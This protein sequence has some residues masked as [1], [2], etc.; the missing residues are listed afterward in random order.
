MAKQNGLA[1][2]TLDLDDAGGTPRDIRS[3]VN[4]FDFATPRA[5]QE[6]TGIDKSA[7]ERILNLADFSCNLKGT[8]NPA[9][10]MSHDVLSSASSS[11]S[12]RTLALGVSGASLINEVLVTDYKLNRDQGGSL[13]WDSPCVLQDG[14]VPT[15]T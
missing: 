5:V 13:D 15:W 1:W 12:P 7:V 8:F 2:D 6:V 3:D 10:N 11:S 14:V 9:V 4:S